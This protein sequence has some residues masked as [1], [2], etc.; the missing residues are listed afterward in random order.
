MTASFSV[1]AHPAVQQFAAKRLERLAPVLEALRRRLGGELVAL[2]DERI[3]E[4]RLPPRRR[5]ACG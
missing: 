5:V 1:G 3:N 4:V 2:L